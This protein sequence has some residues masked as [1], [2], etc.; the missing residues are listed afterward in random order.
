MKSTFSSLGHEFLTLDK[1]LH[2]LANLLKSAQNNLVALNKAIALVLDCCLV[3]ELADQNLQST[4]V[5][6]RHAREEMVDGLE[7]KASVQEIQPGGAVDIHGSAQLTLGEALGRTQISGGHAPVAQSD[8][9]VQ[10]H[11]DTMRDEDECNSNGPSGKCAPEESVAEYSPVA[12]HEENLNWASPPSR[13][14][15]GSAR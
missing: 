12:G 9:N 8:L 1:S 3:T 15:V 4:Q 6:A 11:S 5:V 13:A 7:L 2:H 14:E 10:E